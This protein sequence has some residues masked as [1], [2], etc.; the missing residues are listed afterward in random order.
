MNKRILIGCILVVFMLVAISMATAV[1]NEKNTEK[2]ESPLF[3]TR[4]KQATGEKL[5][6]F[7]EN[8]KARFIGERIYL[9][10]FLFKNHRATLLTTHQWT[11]C[12][13]VGCLKC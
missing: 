5:S 7:R 2:K 12:S 13:T 1:S 4:T 3:K 8:I 11:D 10:P 6:R 9:L